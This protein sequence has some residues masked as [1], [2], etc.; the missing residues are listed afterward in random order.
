MGHLAT[1]GDP[2]GE[3]KGSALGRP[4]ESLAGKGRKINGEE[5]TES[6][7]SGR[8]SAEGV[9]NWFSPGFGPQFKTKPMVSTFPGPRATSNAFTTVS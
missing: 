9:T 7:P 6:R 1:A 8:L 2:M 3:E 5:K 4:W